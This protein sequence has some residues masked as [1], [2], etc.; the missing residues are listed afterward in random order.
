MSRTLREAFNDADP[1]KTADLMRKVR[2]GDVLALGPRSVVGAVSGDVLTLPEGAKAVRL[3]KGYA[4]AGTAT[5]YLEPIADDDTLAA[6]E[7]QITPTGDVAFFATDAVTEAEVTYLTQEG[8][9]VEQVLPVSSDL[10]ALA[11][12]A[13]GVI[14]LEAEAL[15]GS[16]TGT[17][18]VVARGTTPSPGEAALTDDGASVEFAAADAVTS[19][20][21]KVVCFPGAAPDSDNL[22]LAGELEDEIGW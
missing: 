7:I 19:A 21:V 6:G 17:A 5:G 11:Q 10:A 2:M 20:R 18:T 8:E 16:A 9:V 22:G 4:R 3:L 1:N 13:E 15:A 14:L 12:G